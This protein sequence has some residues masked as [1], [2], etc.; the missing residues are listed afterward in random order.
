MG[1]NTEKLYVG[2]FIIFCMWLLIMCIIGCNIPRNASRVS[3]FDCSVRDASTPAHFHFDFSQPVIEVKD[4]ISVY[5][6]PT[7]RV[8]D[9]TIE[10]EPHEHIYTK[11][12][13]SYQDSVTYGYNN[14]TQYDWTL[15]VC[16][17]CQKINICK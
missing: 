1:N 14:S 16:I 8:M 5:R 10:P 12:A 11:V 4:T 6:M 3:E 13:Y 7:V 2:L 15:C 9:I 17:I